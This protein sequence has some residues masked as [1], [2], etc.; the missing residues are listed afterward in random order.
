MVGWPSAAQGHLPAHAL[1]FWPGCPDVPRGPGEERRVAGAPPRQREAA[2]A[3]AGAVRSRW[4]SLVHRAHAVDPAAAHWTGVLP[5]TPAT[6]LA[7]HCGLAAGWHTSKR[8]L[9]ARRVV[10]PAARAC[11]RGRPCPWAGLV[12]TCLARARRAV[13]LLRRIWPRVWRA[14]EASEEAGTPG[15]VPAE[16]VGG[17]LDVAAFGGVDAQE[18]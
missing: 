14:C 2:S 4:P 8:R 13:P 1:D 16:E 18:E 11:P 10:S 17:V 6:L 3:R 15:P 5:V 7:W 12:F 9:P